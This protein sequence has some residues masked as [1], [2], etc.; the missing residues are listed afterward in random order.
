M[1]ILSGNL[2][3][4]ILTLLFKKGPMT[5]VEIGMELKRK[6]KKA[7]K[8]GVYR[9]LRKL[10]N[11][12]KT[13]TYKSLISLNDLWVFK[14]RT[15]IEEHAGPASL[16]G[17]VNTLR[18]GERIL[19]KIKSLTHTDQIWT[20]IFLNIEGNTRSNDPIFLYNTHNWSTPLRR[21][22]D[23]VHIE[24]F[25]RYNKKVYT[26]T[27]GNTDLDHELARIFRRKGL[28]CIKETSIKAKEAVAVIEDFLIRIK[29]RGQ[30]NAVIDR[31]F[32][33]SKDLDELST[34]LYELDRKVVATLIVEHS[35][36]KSSE[37]RRRLSK[38]LA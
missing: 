25:S 37:W 21:A 3:E 19:L 26:F 14:L 24:R 6:K 9:I 38:H 34:K 12:E 23:Y 4:A 10:R 22:T 17:D 13:T 27:S 30:D 32:Q 16:V 15:L 20:N 33:K 8:Q 29:I 11:E 31:A 2:E 1:K 28:P 35:K 36:R 18:D 7:T 5:A